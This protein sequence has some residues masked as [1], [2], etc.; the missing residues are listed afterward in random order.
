MI[1]RFDV[2]GHI[3]PK[4][5]KDIKKSVLGL[6]FEKLDRDAFDPNDC[7]DYVAK[8]GVKW[9]RLQSGWQKTEREKGVYN[10]KWLDEVVDR[11]I[12]DG[13]EPWLCLCYGNDLYSEAAKLHYGAVGCPPIFTEEERRAWHDYVV[14]TV[15][16][17]KGRI[18]Y[19]EVWNEPDGKWCW[20]HGPNATELGHLN[21]AT[22]DACKEADPSCEVI[23]LVTCTNSHE[24]LEE[25][26]ATGA[27]EHLDAISYHAYT[28][29]DRTYDEIYEKYVDLCKRHKP[30]MKIIQGETGTQSQYSHSG[31]NK[32]IN[33]DEY[34]QANLLLKHFL[35]DIR[36][37][38]PLTSYFSCIDMKEALNGVVGDK[39]SVKD[40]GYF[41]VIGCD[42]FDENDRPFGIHPK[43][44]YKA[45]QNICSVF[46]DDYT[47]GNCF[48]LHFGQGYAR[49]T[50]CNDVE[51]SRL[52]H[53]Q[54]S[55]PNGSKALVY[56]VDTNNIV[57]KVDGTT[58]VRIP[59]K[60]FSK[61]WRIVDL[62]TG[63]I[64]KVKDIYLDDIETK[65][66]DDIILKNIPA[67]DRPLMLTFGDFAEMM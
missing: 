3:K 23:G 35:R 49:F 62:M 44:S 22:A 51:K 30:G 32:F 31:A 27:L 2:E 18:H 47:V 57:D 6:G 4:A 5:S 7:Y 14:A 45:L 19:Y 46:S 42:G 26:A 20:K 12:S 56:W 8:S 28:T 50:D 40:Y 67:Y 17:F 37:G 10:F 55:K 29:H 36:N 61:D 59:E 15:T 13:V 16:H 25:F 38:V 66:N 60:A 39:D 54:V 34:K 53:F 52:F 9:A 41:G 43:K 21:I 63:E 48:S 65:E 64:V 33:L 11:L 58:T 1:Q 24:F